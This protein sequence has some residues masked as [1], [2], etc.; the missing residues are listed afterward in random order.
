MQFVLTIVL[1]LPNPQDYSESTIFGE[2]LNKQIDRFCNL[3]ITCINLM[4]F[5]KKVMHEIIFQVIAKLCLSFMCCVFS[6]IFK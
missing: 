1:I 2:N 4:I 5:G 6:Y 3:G